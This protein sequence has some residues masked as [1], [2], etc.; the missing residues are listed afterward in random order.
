MGVF[1]G[2]A[3]PF[4]PFNLTLFVVFEVM[5]I[6]LETWVLW[7][8]GHKWLKI[9]S[10]KGEVTYFGLGD[11]FMF[12]FLMNVVSALIAIPIWLMLGVGV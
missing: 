8:F 2:T 5:T 11:A 9:L 1:N 6:L 3:S 4:L 12:S 10:D 7:V